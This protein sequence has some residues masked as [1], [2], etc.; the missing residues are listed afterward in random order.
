MNQMHRREF[1]GR[2][3]AAGTAVVGVGA[4]PQVLAQG[5]F[6][7]GQQYLRFSPPL[8]VS[9]PA[10][11]IEVIE[12]F[13]YA[14]PHCYAFEPSLNEW[15]R[16]LPADVVFRRVPVPFL[17]NAENF[18]RGYYALEALG[19][20]ELAHARIFTAVHRDHKIPSRPEAMADLVAQGG[21]DRE[22]FLAAFN[23][24]GVASKLTQGKTL[25]ERYKINGVPSLGIH[26][27]FLTSPSLVGRDAL[28]ETE[29]QSM[30]LALTDQLIA[31]ARK[32]G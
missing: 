14:C 26:G 22:K 3:A 29:S 25:M 7:E 6:V 30:A 12:F 13:S 28:P 27:R 1:M 4:A 2:C 10:G 19:Q 17:I 24:F 23:S 32:G 11:K 15:T 16:K 31:R 5:N 18:Q 21:V 8:P 20:V 9:V